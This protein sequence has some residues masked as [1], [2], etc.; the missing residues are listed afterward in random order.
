[1]SENNTIVIPK[2]SLKSLECALSDFI[3]VVEVNK[4][5]RQSKDPSDEQVELLN[6]F[7]LEL[8]V[9]RMKFFPERR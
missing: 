1:M 4:K 9:L 8:E 5:L 3:T 7:Q 2:I 6:L